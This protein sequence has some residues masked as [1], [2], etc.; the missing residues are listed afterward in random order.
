MLKHQSQIQFKSHP[1][2]VIFV[3]WSVDESFRGP[4]R[5]CPLHSSLTRRSS[6]HSTSPTSHLLVP[7]PRSFS[8]L[9]S[10]C[11]EATTVGRARC[12]KPGY[13]LWYSLDPQSTRSSLPPNSE[14]GDGPSLPSAVSL[15]VPH[16]DGHRDKSASSLPRQTSHQGMHAFS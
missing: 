15:S 2:L 11:Q 3:V 13:F 9:D 8:L 10:P 4:C 6:S 14:S 5:T 1:F 16:P 12:L 7:T